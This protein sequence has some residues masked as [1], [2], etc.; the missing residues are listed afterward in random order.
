MKQ[1]LC[2]FLICLVLAF[3]AGCK[4]AAEG[5]KEAPT[6]ASEDIS[7]V[8]KGLSDIEGLDEDLD[9]SELDDLELELEDIEW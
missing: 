6:S 4:P 9:I 2:I 3:I 7:D 5:I 1:I 8:G